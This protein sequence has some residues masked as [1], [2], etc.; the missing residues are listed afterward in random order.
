M[1]AIFFILKVFISHFAVHLLVQY[2]ISTALLDMPLI[3]F[4]FLLYETF[5]IFHKNLV[6]S[7]FCFFTFFS[8]LCVCVYF[9]H[10]LFD[11]FFAL[12]VR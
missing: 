4:N 3:F 6:F 7:S 11:F 1:P 8:L 10:S 2:T 12:L 5:F 9:F